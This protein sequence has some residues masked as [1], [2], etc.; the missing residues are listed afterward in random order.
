MSADVAAELLSHVAAEARQRS[1]A[2]WYAMG[3]WVM[4]GL[5]FCSAATL[6][7]TAERTFA[8][9][10]AAVAPRRRNDATGDSAVERLARA[11]QRETRSPGAYE[12]GFVV[13]CGR[14]RRNLALLAAVA[15]LATM[16]GLLGT[17]LGMTSAF[18]LISRTGTGDARVVASGIFEALVT[19][20][21]GLSI[22]VVATA[23]HA[24]LRRRV[25]H[26]EIELVERTDPGASAAE[27]GRE[28]REPARSG[29][30]ISAAAVDLP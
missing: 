11:A 20:A 21:A 5:A 7:L 15:Q 30:A 28:V 3:G 14:L 9:R 13:E 19:T 18:D 24:L 27:A 17:V 23:C 2:E 10:R 6:A 1:V 8:L 22:A 25:E 29:E 16:L 4:H 26:W 12:R